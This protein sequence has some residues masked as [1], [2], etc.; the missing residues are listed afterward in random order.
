[1]FRRF[2]SF[3][4]FVLTNGEVVISTESLDLSRYKCPL[5]S[6]VIADELG[7]NVALATKDKDTNLH[8]GKGCEKEETTYTS[9]SPVQK[10]KFLPILALSFNLWVPCEGLSI[11]VV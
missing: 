1:M 7:N 2:S 9:G 3:I 5:P 4:N 10:E 6:G 11:L 8:A